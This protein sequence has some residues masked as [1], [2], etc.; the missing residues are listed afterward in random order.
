MDG[1]NLFLD[2][3]MTSCRD[4]LPTLTKVCEPQS[5]WGQALY[6]ISGAAGICHVSDA[7]VGFLNM[8]DN[9]STSNTSMHEKAN[10]RA[11]LTALLPGTVSSGLVLP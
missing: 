11:R 5:W 1:S 10:Y 4:S 8:I 7:S 6:W 9:L 3:V 2:S